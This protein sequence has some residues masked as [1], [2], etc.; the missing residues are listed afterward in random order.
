MHLGERSLLQQPPPPAG[1]R[2]GEGRHWATMGAAVGWERT[3]DSSKSPRRQA[4]RGCHPRAEA[5]PVREGLRRITRWLAA[6]SAAA[7][8]A[9]ALWLVADAALYQ[10]ANPAP[11]NF[12]EGFM[13][14]DALRVAASGALYNDPRQPP[15]SLHVY[16]PLY[17]VALASL[18]RAGAEPFV[19]GRRLSLAGS[20]AVALLVLWA[21]W[22]R[23]RTV[24][25]AAASLWLLAPLQWPWSLVVRPDTWAVALS[26]AGVVLVARRNG[27]CVPPLAVV[28][29]L[30]AL[31]TKQTAV[32]GAAASL[33]AVAR[34][35]PRRALRSAATLAAAAALVTLALEWASDGWFLFHTVAGNW[36]AYS[37]ARAVALWGTFLRHHVVEA[38]VLVA[39]LLWQAATRHLDVPGIY[40]LLACAVAWGAGKVGSDLNYFLELLAATAL[41]AASGVPQRGP[42]GSGRFGAVVSCAAVLAGLL[43][44]VVHVDDQLG[45]RRGFAALAPVAREVTARVGA[46]GGVV[47]SDEA[48]LL[49][50]A[51][52]PVFFQPFVMTQLAAAGRWDERPFLAAL[53]DGTVAAVIVQEAPPEVVPTRYSEAVRR[54]LATRYAPRWGFG[55]GFLYRVW[56]PRPVGTNEQGSIT[57]KAA[58]GG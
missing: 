5:V 18:A 7:L 45:R 11:L 21:G 39:L 28:L 55:L 52:K 27:E 33:V 41:L 20:V 29:F 24:A 38:T 23:H 32:A 34:R 51:G 17:T 43:L 16:T 25:V 53:A 26:L 13:V 1:P 47:V 49:V 58:A 31:F 2:R 54:I 12:V 35:D 44:G 46:M 3:R 10:A 19:A 37:L 40:A 8:A 50:R 30:A 56:E 36:N 6:S 9:G 42:A 22:R 14:A 48:S 4:E 57:M 15:F